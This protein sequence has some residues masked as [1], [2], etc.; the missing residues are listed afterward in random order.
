MFAFFARALCGALVLAGLASEQL[1]PV[2]TEPGS[3]QTQMNA[4][5]PRADSVTIQPPYEYQE[6]AVYRI[7]RVTAYCDRGL[8]AAGV[9]SGIG[10]C[11]APADIPFGARIYIPA[12]HRTFIVTDRTAKRFRH[13]TVDLFIPDRNECLQFGRRYLECEIAFPAQPARYGS[14][15]LR[16]AA[17]GAHQ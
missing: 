4:A 2:K 12:L 9:P 17:A 15:R 14:P 10:Q 6:E 11:A 7:Y 5:A 3:F 13:N 8:T 16:A 1:S